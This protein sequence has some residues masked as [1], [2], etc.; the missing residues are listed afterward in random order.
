M[1]SKIRCFPQ[2]RLAKMT[3][4]TKGQFVVVDG[5]PG[6]KVLEKTE[7]L[8]EGCGIRMYLF[9]DEILTAE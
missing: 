5:R 3:I 1:M 8:E 2:A 7:I 4:T 9:P 6:F